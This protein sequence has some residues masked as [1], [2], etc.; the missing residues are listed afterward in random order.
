MEEKDSYLYLYSYLFRTHYLL[1]PKMYSY[2]VIIIVATVYHGYYIQVISC[3]FTVNTLVWCSLN[4]MPD[5]CLLVDM[6]VFL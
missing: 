1:V 3:T 2:L 4:E 6:R 5:I